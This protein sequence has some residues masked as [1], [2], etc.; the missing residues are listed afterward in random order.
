MQKD[1]YAQTLGT[2]TRHVYARLMERFPPTTFV[3]A[4]GV[5]IEIIDDASTYAAW[6]DAEGTDNWDVWL[7]GAAKNSAHKNLI[8]EVLRKGYD[9][10][11]VRL[12]DQ[13]QDG[14]ATAAAVIRANSRAK[15]QLMEMYKQELDER[16]WS[17]TQVDEDYKDGHS[18]YTQFHAT[19][20]FCRVRF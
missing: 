14:E 18:I 3:D 2:E 16:R 11:V 9:A 20:N 17:G 19:L 7:E 10:N 6:L 8:V 13:N 5:E 4:E 12:L 15:E 1:A